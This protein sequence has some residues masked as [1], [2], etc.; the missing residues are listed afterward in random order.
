MLD[1]TNTRIANIIK[2]A[3]ITSGEHNKQ[4]VYQTANITNAR[5]NKHW[6]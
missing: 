3:D 4:Q 1:I 2:Y 6:T 5:Q